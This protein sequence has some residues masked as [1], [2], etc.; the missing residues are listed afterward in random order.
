MTE[1]TFPS[2]IPRI[3]REFGTPVAASQPSTLA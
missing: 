3:L 2:L 1:Q